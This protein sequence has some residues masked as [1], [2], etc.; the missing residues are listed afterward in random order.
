MQKMI[1]CLWFDHGKGDEAME[2]YASVFPDSKVLSVTKYGDFAPGL[3]GKTLTATLRLAGQEVML[4][5]G[6][7]KFA[8]SE[9]VSLMVRCESQEEIDGYWAKLLAGGGEESM[10]GWL[11]DRFGFSWQI[12]PARLDRWLTDH[13]QAKVNRLMRAVMGMRKL[14]MAAMEK[15]YQGG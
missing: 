13:D 3:E 6:G 1:P 14:D 7:P 12:V 4:L 11:K 9:A 5:C 2:F 15:A 10:C 8:F